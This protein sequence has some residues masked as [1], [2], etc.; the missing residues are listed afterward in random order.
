MVTLAFIDVNSN[1]NTFSLK[2][3][4]LI[5]RPL[6]LLSI[7]T[8]TIVIGLR[9]D[10]GIDWKNYKALLEE[11]INKGTTNSEIEYG[12]YLLM[13]TVYYLRLNY[14]S[15]FIF[16]AFLQI[17]FLYA[18]GKDFNKVFPFMI[19][20]FFTMGNFI[21]SLN[22]MRQMMAISIIFYGTKFIINKNFIAWLLI[23]VLAF[24]IHKTAI[25][26]IPFYFLNKN[27]SKN[28]II[29][30][31]ILVLVYIT[32]KYVIVE[33]LEGLLNFSNLLFGRESSLVSIYNQNRDV[34]ANGGSGLFLLSE[35][36]FYAIMLYFYSECANEFKTN[37]FYLFFNLTA[38]GIVLFPL[39]SDNILLDRIIY[40][41]GAFKFVTFGFYVY[42][43]IYHRKMWF[44][45]F[46]GVAIIIAYFID[47]LMRIAGS[48]NQCS[49]FQFI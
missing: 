42:Y 12:Y 32:M 49:P 4:S 16:I 8:F 37:G 3:K 35:I 7:L 43:F 13:K 1:G 46:L 45:N 11:L 36:I 20:F 19:I 24:F 39:V 25:I 28:R 31:G 30:I 6:L 47:F 29:F 5:S 41:F 17:V 33:R 18:R 14:V 26:C 23:C 15:I 48:S 22:I 9:Y 21:Y 44:L 34:I 10:V 27:L 38:F 2:K 40:Y